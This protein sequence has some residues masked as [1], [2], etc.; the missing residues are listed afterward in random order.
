MKKLL[1]LTI[2]V[3]FVMLP[4][5]SFGKTVISDSDLEEVTA[6][7]GVSVN[8]S[9]F[10]VRGTAT[11]GTTSWGDSDGYPTASYNSP[12]YAGANGVSL[13]G[14]IVSFNA[15]PLNVDVGTSGSSTRVNFTLPTTTLGSVNVDS[16]MKL[17]SAMDLS[18]GNEL[19]RMNVQGLSTQ[20]TSDRVQVFAH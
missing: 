17:S 2:A 10:S 16:T 12:G 3:G 5:A 6:E 4:F 7:E 13:S 11:V 19:G 1:I 8:F 14:N 15:T 9:N 20:V 18:G